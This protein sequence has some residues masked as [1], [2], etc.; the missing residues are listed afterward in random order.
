MSQWSVG[1]WKTNQRVG[2]RWVGGGL[3]GESVGRWRKCLWVGSGLSVVGV[4]S[5]VS[6]LVSRLFSIS[7][8]LIQNQE[9]FIWNYSKM[10]NLFHF[11]CLLRSYKG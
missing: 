10:I 2:G 3:V 11:E 1:Q 4:L 6:G 8:T 7:T 9:I 5:M